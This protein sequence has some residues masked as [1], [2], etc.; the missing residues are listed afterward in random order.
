MIIKSIGLIAATVVILFN[1]C[2]PCGAVTS[3]GLFE[4]VAKEEAATAAG[5]KNWIDIEREK[6]AEKYGTT[7][8][9]LLNYQNLWALRSSENERDNRGA[10]YYNLAI[11]QKLWRGASFVATAE[12]GKGKGIDK[13][14]PTFSVYDGSDGEIS[15][16]YVPELY[17]DQNFFDGKF[18]I[19][20]GRTDL[21]NW[22]DDSEVANISDTQFLSSALV[23]NPVIPFPQ[24]GLAAM[25]G[26]KPED[27]LCLQTGVSN[28]KASST[29]IGLRSAFK[30][31]P[32][33]FFINEICFCP[34]IGQLQGNYRFSLRRNFQ[35]LD[36]IDGSGIQHDD[37]GFSLSFDQQVTQKV[38]LFCRYGFADKRVSDLSNFWSAGGQITGPI[39]GRKGDIFGMAVAQSFLGDDYLRANGPGLAS[40]ET[41]FE[42]YYSIELNRIL[43]LIP[44]LQFV[45]NPDG[46]ANAKN[47]IVG[48]A[49]LILIF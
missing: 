22:F 15:Y 32:A 7:F 8:A 37:W 35:D 42:T 1:I 45:T 34:K 29:Q 5:Q 30:D 27:W 47:E 4:E 33:W 39:P 21:S 17:L 19:N 6:F 23:N 20:A 49:R 10:W 14:L 3:T 9:F 31:D 41:M 46:E 40:R 18:Y 26:I 13:L 28:A 16:L 2:P 43:T 38:T 24:K 25:A 36:R 11:D 44:S 48:G 12:G